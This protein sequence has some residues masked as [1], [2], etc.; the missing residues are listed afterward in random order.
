MAFLHVSALLALFGLVAMWVVSYVLERRIGQRFKDVA[1]MVR[2][3][4]LPCL[5]ALWL[6]DGLFGYGRQTPEFKLV[7]T[8]FG[9]AVVWFVASTVQSLFLAEAQ[10]SAVRSRT[11][12]LLVDIVRLCF[13]IIGMVMVYSGVWQKD[14]SPLLT[15]FGVGSLVVGLALQDTLGNL[16]AG[17]ALIFERPLAVGDWVQVGDTVGKVR[18]ITWR[19]VRIVT[20]ELN[21]ITVPNSAISKDRIMNYSSPSRLY[22]FKVTI[23]FSYD[24]PPSVVKEMLRSTALETP[25]I[26]ATPAPDPRTLEFAASSVTY[27]LRVFID[28]YD[29]FTDVR[30]ELMSRIWYSAR[31]AGIQIP[32]PIT[33]IHKTEIPYQHPARD[34]EEHFKEILRATELFKELTDVEVDLLSHEV[35][36]DRYGKGEVLL[37]EGEVGDHF[38]IILDGTCSVAVTSSQG[39]AIGVAAVRS[40]DVVGEMALLAGA[41]RTATVRAS[42]DVKAARVGKEALSALL[43]QR[44]DLVQV[45]AHYTAKRATEIEEARVIESQIVRTR[46]GEIDERALGERIKRFLGLPA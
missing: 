24:A 4:V 46:S 40:G 38:F 15:T 44:T 26:V 22:G 9:F 37:R 31:R 35:S 20:R 32:Y 6:V 17:L 34:G 27:E 33:T 12:R 36:I 28:D 11:P 41:T 23:G 13:V 45:F 5:L 39:G 10:A 14:V 2:G 3:L 25:G 7:E 21:E 16:F 8:I 30:N 19:S 42:S 18:Q 29:H 1:R 43:S